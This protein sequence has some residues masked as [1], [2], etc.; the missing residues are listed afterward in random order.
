MSKLV[1]I[2]GGSGFV[3]RYIARR[4]ARWAGA[5]ALPYAARTR[6][7]LSNPMASLARSSRSCA[8][9]AMTASVRAC[10]GRRGCGCELRGHS[11]R[12][13]QE[14]L[15]RVQARRCGADRVGSPARRGGVGRMVHIS[16]IGADA[17]ATATMP[18]PKARARRVF[19]HMPDAVILRPSIIF[20]P[21][22]Q[23]FNRFAGHGAVGS[24]LPVG[25]RRHPVSSRSMSM[26]WPGC[27]WASTRATAGVY[28]LGGPEV[29]T[30]FRGLMGDMLAVIIR[31]RLL[32]H[33]GNLPFW[34]GRR[35]WH[36]VWTFGCK[37]RVSFRAV[38]Q[39]R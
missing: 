1:T 34:V 2:Y 37:G 9:S 13:G 21:E 35:S 16:A 12:S 6:R 14:S 24:V 20:R 32:I 26:M 19:W 15:R 5:C 33:S 18:A 30:T 4:M 28:E 17:D 23:F 22:D 3:G 29:R 39:R 27:R 25:G 7:C 8:T 36:S 10:D 31:R 11:E 38:P